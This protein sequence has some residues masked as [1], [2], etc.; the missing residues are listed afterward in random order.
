MTIYY[1]FFMISNHLSTYLSIYLPTFT[2]IPI[3]IQ[4]FFFYF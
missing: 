4:T 2:S 3:Y 1:L